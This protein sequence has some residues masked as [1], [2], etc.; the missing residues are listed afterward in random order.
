MRYPFRRAAC[1]AV[2]LACTV[3]PA[4]VVAQGAAAPLRDVEAAADSATTSPVPV[5]TGRARFLDPEDGQFDLSYFLENPRGFLPV[6]IVVTEPAVGYGGGGAGLF[7]RPR[8]EAGEEGWARPNIS[9]VGGLVTQ[10]GTWAGFGG[11]SSRFLDGRLRTLAGGGAGQVNLDFYGLSGGPSSR[12]QGVRYSLTFAAAVGQANWQLAPKSPWAAGV[13]YVYASVN[14]RLRDEPLFPDLADRIRVTVSAPTAILEYDS[15]DNVFTPTR[16][17]YSESAYLASREALGASVDFER[18]DQVLLGWHP[19][20]HDVTLG[21]NGTYSWSSQGTP[22]FLRPF[23]MLR[24]VPAMR[25]QGDQV[26]SIEL[27]ARWQFHGRWSVVAFGGAGRAWTERTNRS[28]QQS[29]GS[30]G[31]G[32][33]YELARKFGLHVG[34]DVAA[35]PG[36]TAF[37]FVIGNAWFR[38]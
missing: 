29:V 7:L 20:R 28:F 17:V 9:A 31:A 18:F 8:K 2:A 12:D 16:G 10:N 6:P 24:G 22:F 1:V 34:I 36:T 37:Y 38:P 13:R 19:L 3:A 33:R 15:R 14:P 25:Y 26:A 4:A 30:G 35:S 21:A 32:F 23:I 11:D 5:R 27:E